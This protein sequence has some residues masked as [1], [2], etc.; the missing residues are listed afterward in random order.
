MGAINIGDFIPCLDWLDLQGLRGRMKSAHQRIDAVFDKIIE[1]HV[2]RK[3]R[4]STEEEE[5]ER[6]EDLVDMLVDTEITVEDKKAILIVH[7]NHFYIHIGMGNVRV[8]EKFKCDEEI[9]R[10]N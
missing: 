8:I 5:E 2:E 10:R 1:E 7:T 9:A 6:Q 3:A 4:R